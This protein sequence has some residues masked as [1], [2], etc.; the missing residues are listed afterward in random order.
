[1]WSITGVSSG[2]GK[3][4]L[5][6]RHHLRRG[7]A[8]VHGV[9]VGLRPPV[10][11][12]AQEARRRRDRGHPAHHR[13]R[14]A[15]RQRHTPAPPSPPPPR[16][17][18]TCASSSPAAARLL[19]GPHQDQKRRHRHR[20]LR[21]PHQATSATQIVDA[22]MTRPA[23][24]RA[25]WSSRPSSAEE[26]L[27]PRRARRLLARAGVAPASTAPSSSCATCSRTPGENP[28]NLGRYEKHDIEA[29]VDR[30]V[31][32]RTSASASPSP[33]RP[34]SAGRRRGDHLVE[35]TAANTWSSTGPSAPSSPTPSTPSTPSK[36]SHP[37]CSPS[38]RPTA[39]APPATAWAPSSS[40]TKTSSSPTKDK[41]L[42]PRARSP[43]KKNG[44]AA[45]F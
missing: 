4:S 26:G 6:L 22:V 31:L 17:T 15:L 39:R 37:A 10:P 7:P 43:W 35:E 27:P 14:A 12:P 45:W 36:N 23:G 32:G 8:Q 1:M 9:A 38:T 29:V 16:S 18:T 33:S 25:A 28:L 41:A 42:S 21:H 5:G 2:S 13:H 44:P 20:A 19:L 24:T 3:S 11:R 30:L 34:R 40:S